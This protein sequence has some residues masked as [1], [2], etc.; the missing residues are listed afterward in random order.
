MAETIIDV[1]AANVLIPTF[2]GRMPCRIRWKE[3]ELPSA[4][5]KIIDLPK[6]DGGTR[7]IY[8]P[9][10]HLRFHLRY[11]ARAFNRLF[12]LIK[13]NQVK[14]SLE[15]IVFE[16]VCA[17]VRR[18]DPVSA[19]LRHSP[20]VYTI[21]IDIRR[22][23]DSITPDILSAGVHTCPVVSNYAGPLSSNKTGLFIDGH[24]PQGY[25]TSPML[26]NFALLGADYFAVS[27]LKSKESRFVYTRYAD[28]ITVSVNNK[29]LVDYAIGAVVGALGI[30]GLSTAEDKL[31]VQ[32][33]R[34]NRRRILGVSVDD[35]GVYPTR[36]TVRRLQRLQ[37][38]D[39]RRGYKSS[40]TLGLE[41]WVKHITDVR[42][43]FQMELQDKIMR[44]L[45]RN[46]D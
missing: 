17:F 26:C 44:D 12:E 1:P 43:Q 33:G 21:Q 36:E 6:P 13:S 22:C 5:V 15:R 35:M 41:A 14:G 2:R 42:D 24:L 40:Q 23:F 16:A 4:K 18:G 3:K 37:R 28:D 10:R 11:M 39:A 30:Y 19:A 9:D 34:S 32:C 38:V 46:N 29:D 45:R 7:R 27:A 20:Y 8:S 31:K 25:S